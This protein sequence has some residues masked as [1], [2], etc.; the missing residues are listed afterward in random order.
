MCLLSVLKGQQHTCY[1]RLL[2]HAY[3]PTVL[4]NHHSQHVSQR[5]TQSLPQRLISTKLI[6]T[7]AP[8]GLEIKTYYWLRPKGMVC[9]PR[10]YI[11]IA[12]IFDA[13]GV[14]ITYF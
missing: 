14:Y 4:S 2:P 7:T 6:T 13:N 3:L 8:N 1:F 11:N 9:F 12:I 10:E 5:L